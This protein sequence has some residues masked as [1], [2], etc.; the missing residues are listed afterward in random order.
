MVGQKIKEVFNIVQKGDSVKFS[1]IKRTNLYVTLFQ[2][3]RDYPVIKVFLPK[4]ISK[5]DFKLKGNGD[6]I[7]K[8]SFT[9]NKSFF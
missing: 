8:N 9:I 3:N 5:F 7:F 1:Q 4:N 2:R 6:L